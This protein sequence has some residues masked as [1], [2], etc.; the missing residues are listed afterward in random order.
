M[1]LFTKVI[2]ALAVLL[3]AIGMVSMTIQA[4][5]PFIAIVIVLSVLGFLFYLFSDEEE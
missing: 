4:A 1:G 2:T 3:L 5:A